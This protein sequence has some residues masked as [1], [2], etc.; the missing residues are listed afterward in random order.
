MKEKANKARQ[1]WNALTIEQQQG[2]MALVIQ[3]ESGKH[4]T[5]ETIVNRAMT[6]HD[7]SCHVGLKL[8]NP[9]LE[10]TL[11]NEV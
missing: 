6:I 5:L 8:G 9:N 10:N 4:A 11:Y 2:Y 1:A 3:R 7:K